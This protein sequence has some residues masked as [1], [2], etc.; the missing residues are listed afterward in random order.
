MT[1]LHDFKNLYIKSLPFIL[2]QTSYLGFLQ[3]LTNEPK[4]KNVIVYT[5][6]GVATGI[7]YPVS[8]PIIGYSLYTKKIKNGFDI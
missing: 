5:G 7:L 8:F 3:E 2:S 1:L 6:I 4:T